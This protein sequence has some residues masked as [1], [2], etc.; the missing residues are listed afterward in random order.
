VRFDKGIG[1]SVREYYINDGLYQSFNCML[2]DHSVLLEESDQEE[3]CTE[4]TK[5]HSAIFGQTCDGLDQISKKIMLPDL[6]VG[7]WLAVPNMGAY[8][9]GASSQ[10]NGFPLNDSIVLDEPIDEQ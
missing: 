2:Y 4:I 1:R 9:N 10:F 5:Y 8:T 3:P 7:D 6:R